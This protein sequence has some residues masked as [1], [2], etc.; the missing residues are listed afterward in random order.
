M[1]SGVCVWQCVSFPYF[2][3]LNTGYGLLPDFEKVN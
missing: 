3:T 2:A 1:E